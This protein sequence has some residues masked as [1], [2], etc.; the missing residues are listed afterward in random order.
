MSGR[1]RFASVFEHAGT[2]IARQIEPRPGRIRVLVGRR[3]PDLL[4]SYSGGSVS[5]S[6]PERRLRRTARRPRSRSRETTSPRRRPRSQ[7]TRDGPIPPPKIRQSC[8]PRLF[9]GCSGPTMPSRTSINC[10]S[11]PT[12]RPERSSAL[13]TGWPR[14]GRPQPSPTSGRLSPDTRA[15]GTGQRRVHKGSSSSRTE[16]AGRYTSQQSRTGVGAGSH[17]EHSAGLTCTGQCATSVRLRWTLRRRTEREL[18]PR[19]G[20]DTADRAR[21]HSRR[22]VPRGVRVETKRQCPVVKQFGADAPRAV[23]MVGRRPESAVRSAHLCRA[24]DAASNCQEGRLSTRRRSAPRAARARA[25]APAGAAMP[26]TASAPPQPA[27]FPSTR[28][29]RPSRRP[30][31]ARGRPTDIR[32]RWAAHARPQE[33]RSPSPRRRRSERRNPGAGRP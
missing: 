3:W 4:P 24:P 29:G 11:V 30:G 13:L 7:S 25:P 15:S 6:H 27:R 16:R 2:E 8:R 23:H 14:C 31:R 21:P 26:R 28:R 22:R 20:G 10:A 32:G 17:G 12:P 19:L 33:G 5:H 1:L 18:F 9:C